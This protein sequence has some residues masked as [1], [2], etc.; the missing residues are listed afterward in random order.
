MTQFTIAVARARTSARRVRQN[1]ARL[2]EER[3]PDQES[4]QSMLEA[5][6]CIEA[7]LNMLASQDAAYLAREMYRSEG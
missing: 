5:A 4:M 3:S 6:T 2:L 7:L 1:A